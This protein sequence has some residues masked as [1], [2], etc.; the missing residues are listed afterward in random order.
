MDNFVSVLKNQD[1]LFWTFEVIGQA[2]TLLEDESKISSYE[3]IVK[4]AFWIYGLAVKVL[5]DKTMVDRLGIEKENVQKLLRETILHLSLIFCKF[6]NAKVIEIC[7]QVILVFNFIATKFY[8]LS[9]KTWKHFLVVLIS[10]IN[11]IL[12]TSQNHKLRS[13][14]LKYCMQVLFIG[15]IKSGVYDPQLWLYLSQSSSNWIQLQNSKIYLKTW[16][17]ICI[18]ATIKVLNDF[19]KFPFFTN[20]V[21]K[22]DSQAEAVSSLQITF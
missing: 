3:K 14:I 4:K 2:F 19:Y 13:D 8:K 1:T 16:K 17:C 15:W 7:K 11:H 22:K 20:C 10:I 21:N 12:T 6:D 18:S 9:L 5:L